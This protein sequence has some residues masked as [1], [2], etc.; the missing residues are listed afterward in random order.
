MT[1]W[2]TLTAN[3]EALRRD[4]QTH[5]GGVYP[6]TFDSWVK[7]IKA[8]VADPENVVVV[9]CQQCGQLAFTGTH[10]VL[11]GAPNTNM[12]V[13]NDCFQNRT[14]TCLICEEVHGIDWTVIVVPGGRQ[15][16]QRACSACYNAH[17]TTCRTCNV[18]YRIAEEREEHR[19][20]D[21][22]C[23]ESPAMAFEFPWVNG[24][25][26]PDTRVDVDLGGTGRVTK[27]VIRE[28]GSYFMVTGQNLA[29]GEWRI[30]GTRAYKM[31]RFGYEL[32]Q[33][34]EDLLEQIGR[35]VKNKSG[36]YPTRLKR[37][38]YKERSLKL[39]PE[40]LT[41]VGNKIAQT[42]SNGVYRVEVT[43]DLNLTAAE[44]ANPNSCW[45]SNYKGSRCALKTNGGM[46]LRTF[47]Q[48]GG[49]VGR[50]WLMPLKS[51]PDGGLTPTFA[52]DTG[53]W[54]VFN[55]YGNLEEKTGARVV[56]AMLGADSA[57]LIEFNAER[58]Y[59][60]N[61]RGYLL[62]PE[63]VTAKTTRLHLP[64][65]EHANLYDRENPKPKT[66]EKVL[67]AGGL[68]LTKNM[69]IGA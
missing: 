45:W 36:N 59:V 16:E 63:A 21:Q 58:Y 44:F 52:V 9:S 68:T 69:F 54:F 14:V 39:D 47:D 55:G 24:P 17:Y 67:K 6:Y 51:G 7:K 3:P 66:A 31:Y 25:L 62:G 42:Q 41:Q 2:A 10:R 61:S 15:D 38:A 8:Q 48:H 5:M 64:L 37:F 4:F 29:P 50:V 26:P 32:R 22:M 20:R 33:C 65:A 13:C 1:T 19:H 30:S 12:D 40:H 23:C 57:K 11:R 34:P 18:V 27:A 43:R 35:E 28:V 60:N 56:Q 46:G 49:I 53:V